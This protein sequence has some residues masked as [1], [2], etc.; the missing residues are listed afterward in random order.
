MGGFTNNEGIY[1]MYVL[2]RKEPANNG[3]T[4]YLAPRGGQSAYT[5]SLAKALRF[6]DEEWAKA[7]A[8][9]NEIVVQVAA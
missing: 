9:G 2:Q 8:C 6:Y 1:Q 4:M 5:T 3:H 7:E